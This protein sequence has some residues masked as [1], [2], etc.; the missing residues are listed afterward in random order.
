VVRWLVEE[1]YAD[2]DRVVLVMDNLNTHKLASLYETFYP[3]RVRRIVERLEI[4]YTPK[5]GSWLNMAEIE[6]GV[7]S[8]QCLDRRIADKVELEREVEAWQSERN[9]TQVGVDWQFTTAKARIKLRRPLP[10]YSNW[11]IY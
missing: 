8:G 11:M 3:D 10:N 2:A 7:L 4:H 5:H 9:E 6:L 1:V